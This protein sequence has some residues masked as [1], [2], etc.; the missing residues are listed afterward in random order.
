METENKP[1]RSQPTKQQTRRA[2]PA[3]RLTGRKLL[4]HPSGLEEHQELLNEEKPEAFESTE[5][6]T[7]LETRS[8]KGEDGVT[9]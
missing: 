7:H 9:P 6:T 1:T 2:C 5:G 3:L 8:L 4:E